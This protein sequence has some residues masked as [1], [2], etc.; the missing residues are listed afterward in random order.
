MFVFVF[1]QY[2]KVYKLT[3]DAKYGEFILSLQ[4]IKWI[5]SCYVKVRFVKSL[6]LYQC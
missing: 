3:A 2:E 5:F 6:K 4:E 1:S